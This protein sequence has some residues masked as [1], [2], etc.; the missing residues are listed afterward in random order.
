MLPNRARLGFELG[1]RS[2]EEL[3][4]PYGRDADYMRCFSA[5]TSATNGVVTLYR[6]WLRTARSP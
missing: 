2:A 1:E 3:H 5:S 6:P 4:R